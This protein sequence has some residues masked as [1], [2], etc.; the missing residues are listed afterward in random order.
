MSAC[1]E[2][3]KPAGNARV[4]LKLSLPN[5]GGT[6]RDANVV[7][8]GT[9]SPADAAV[10]VGGR[11]AD[12]EAGEFSLQ[13]DLDPGRNV[14]DVAATSP[15]RRPA[16]DAV[17]VTRDMRVPVPDLVGLEVDQAK[18]A[19][20]DAGLKVQEEQGGSWLDRVIPGTDHV[21]ESDPVAKTPVDKGTTVTIL[22][23]RQC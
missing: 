15:G 18:S 19:L 12:V 21:C 13:V 7:V 8:R 6:T 11:D 16:T 23:A 17:R 22:T 10:R 2:T 5:D 14:I 4:S 9:V 20:G 1:G 3:P